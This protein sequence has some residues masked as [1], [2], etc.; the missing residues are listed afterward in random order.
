MSNPSKQQGTTF[1]SWLVGTFRANGLNSR[2]L[3]EGGSHDLGDL[4]V[5]DW[6]IEAKARSNLNLHQALHKARE[7]APQRRVAVVHKRLTRKE[8][9]QRRTPD[10]EPIVVAMTLDDFVGLLMRE[11]YE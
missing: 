2:R 5:E 1:E 9:N 6:I 7:K 10:G 11:A 8:G 3:A 4:E